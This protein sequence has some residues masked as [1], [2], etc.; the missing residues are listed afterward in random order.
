VST[1][2][3]GRITEADVIVDVSDGS[4]Q[5]PQGYNQRGDCGADG[6]AAVNGGLQ[7]GECQESLR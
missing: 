1:T 2:Q 7:S 3:L 5:L 4:A 6:P